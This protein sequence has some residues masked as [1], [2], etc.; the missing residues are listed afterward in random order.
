MR[1]QSLKS[2]FNGL[3][4]NK[5]S[6][7]LSNISIAFPISKKLNLVLDINR[8]V[9]KDMILSPKILAD[10]TVKANHFMVKVH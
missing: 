10:S 6:N 5:H 1:N 8:I 9:L 4:A 2:D 3:S 7:Y